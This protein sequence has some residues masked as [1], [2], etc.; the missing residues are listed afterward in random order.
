MLHHD[1]NQ[2]DPR[3]EMI[4]PIEHDILERTYLDVVAFEERVRSS[5]GPDL[6]TLVPE[7]HQE[8]FISTLMELIDSDSA[9]SKLA[10]V[11]L[12]NEVLSEVGYAFPVA[13]LHVLWPGAGPTKEE[14]AFLLKHNCDCLAGIAERASSRLTRPVPSRPNKFKL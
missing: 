9:E 7:E 14:T 2:K 3:S 1:P 6:A 8:R 5:L 12:I 4:I 10:Y 11:C 13:D